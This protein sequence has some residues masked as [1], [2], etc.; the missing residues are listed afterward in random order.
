MKDALSVSIQTVALRRA[1]ATI[2]FSLVPEKACESPGEFE[3]EALGLLCF[4]PRS[5]K[6]AGGG[7]V[8]GLGS[9]GLDP[10]KTK[11]TCFLRKSFS[12]QLV[13]DMLRRAAISFRVLQQQTA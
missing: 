3:A 9:S 11:R 12:A 6:A 4:V 7:W 1:R 13:S 8:G 5:K 10:S 2:M